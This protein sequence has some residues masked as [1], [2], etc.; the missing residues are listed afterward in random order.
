[1]QVEQMIDV[2]VPQ[3]ILLLTATSE[4]LSV[5]YATEIIQHDVVR[6]QS[7]RAVFVCDEIFIFII[8]NDV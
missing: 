7:L 1:M 2:F 5:I 4:D 6:D 3:Q 8:V